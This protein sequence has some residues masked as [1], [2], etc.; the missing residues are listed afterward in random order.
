MGKINLRL[1]TFLVPSVKSKHNSKRSK[2]I[3][4]LSGPITKLKPS[5]IKIKIP[6]TQPGKNRMP[7]IKLKIIRHRLY[8]K[9]NS[10]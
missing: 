9:T 10:K 8:E 3:S 2:L 6:N 4:H 5:F 7:G 1:N